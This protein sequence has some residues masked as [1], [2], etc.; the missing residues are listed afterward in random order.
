MNQI[1]IKW[2]RQPA[3]LIRGAGEGVGSCSG[4]TLVFNVNDAQWC[5]LDWAVC[6]GG[7]RS[8]A[9]PGIFAG[10]KAQ[11]QSRLYPL[12]SQGAQPPDTR[13]GKPG[14]ELAC[15]SYRGSHSQPVSAES[16]NASR[17]GHWGNKDQNLK[18]Q[19][20][21][22]F[23]KEPVIPP[24][25]AVGCAASSGLLCPTLP[26][27]CGHCWAAVKRKQQGG[28]DASLPTGSRSGSRPGRCSHASSQHLEGGPRPETGS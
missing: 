22:P 4:R 9:G 23:V 3:G 13:R 14:S 7:H 24:Q 10:S 25:R 16:E 21:V 12:R 8:R 19:A 17:K 18:G 11:P 1:Q 26:H 5:L 28:A 6:A 15:H 2:H 20:P 27:P